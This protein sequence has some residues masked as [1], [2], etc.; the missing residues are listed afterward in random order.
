MIEP[1]GTNVV[2]KPIEETPEGVLLPERARDTLNFGIVWLVGPD[3]KVL[4]RGDLILL[5]S[6]N[7]D[8]LKVDGVEYVMLAEKSIG[9]RISE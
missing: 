4:K 7:D 2:V 8:K 6:W 9:V 3:V 5:P 1:L